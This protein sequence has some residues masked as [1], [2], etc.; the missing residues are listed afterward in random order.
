MFGRSLSG[1]EED[2]EYVQASNSTTYTMITQHD[3]EFKK[4]DLIKIS[5]K[6]SSKV[7]AMGE[8]AYFSRVGSKFEGNMFGHD[9]TVYISKFAGGGQFESK[10]ES[11]PLSPNVLY[12]LEADE[13]IKARKDIDKFVVTTGQ[14]K[15][16]HNSILAGQNIVAKIIFLNNER[17]K[18][19]TRN[20]DF[21][22]SLRGPESDLTDVNP[23]VK[24][25]VGL[26]CITFQVKI[27]KT[28]DYLLFFNQQANST[29]LQGNNAIKL[30]DESGG[31]IPEQGISLIV[32]AGAPSSLVFKSP[33]L[34]VQLSVDVPCFEVAVCDNFRNPVPAVRLKNLAWQ[35]SVLEDDCRFCKDFQV[36]THDGSI[37]ITK[38]RLRETRLRGNEKRLI[39]V[40]LHAD[41]IQCE[42]V[43]VMEV[44]HGPP[45]LLEIENILKNVKCDT[46]L[47]KVTISV[48]DDSK[49]L[50]TT[51]T[52]TLIA[53][54]DNLCYVSDMNDRPPCQLLVENVNQGKIVFGGRNCAAVQGNIFK[55]AF[56]RSTNSYPVD[57]VLELA[58]NERQQAKTHLYQMNGQKFLVHMPL[59]VFVE[60]DFV[61]CDISDR[62]RVH[63]SRIV[64]SKSVL[65]R[66]DSMDSTAASTKSQA[67][68][69]SGARGVQADAVTVAVTVFESAFDIGEEVQ[70]TSLDFEGLWSATIVGMDD[71]GTYTVRWAEDVVDSEQRVLPQ[72]DLKKRAEDLRKKSK[73][74]RRVRVAKQTVIDA[75]QFLSKAFVFHNSIARKGTVSERE[76][77]EA[78]AQI[79]V[80]I[81]AK[82]VYFCDDDDCAKVLY[83]QIDLLFT[84][85]VGM[86]VDTD[87]N[88][89]DSFQTGD[90]V[91]YCRMKPNLIPSGIPKYAELW[92]RDGTSEMLWQ[93]SECHYDRSQVPAAQSYARD[94]VFQL[95]LK[96]RDESGAPCEYSPDMYDVSCSWE[97]NLE[98][99]RERSL[100]VDGSLPPFTLKKSGNLSVEISVINGRRLKLVHFVKMQYGTAAKINLVVN[101]ECHQEINTVKVGQHYSLSF[102][103]LD[104][105]EEKIP[106]SEFFEFNLTQLYLIDSSR[107]KISVQ[108]RIEDHR[109]GTQLWEDVTSTS[110]HTLERDDKDACFKLSKCCFGGKAGNVQLHMEGFVL[111]SGD[112]K[113]IELKSQFLHV[114]LQPGDAKKIMLINNTFSRP[115]LVDLSTIYLTS[116]EIETNTIRVAATDDYGNRLDCQTLSVSLVLLNPETQKSTR[117]DLVKEAN[118][119][120]SATFTAGPYSPGKIE[121]TI[122]GR[123]RGLNLEPCGITIQVEKSNC[124]ESIELGSAQQKMVVPMLQDKSFC[125]KVNAT[126]HTQDKYA[127]PEQCRS[128]CQLLWVGNGEELRRIPLES[129]GD[130]DWEYGRTVNLT[131]PIPWRKPGAYDLRFEYLEKRE[132]LKDVTSN[133]IA[134]IALPGCP[135][136][137][138]SLYMHSFP[139]VCWPCDSSD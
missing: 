18:V 40:R 93:V 89:H 25:E 112:K 41:A 118:D 26:G 55:D 95:F 11:F 126:F 88:W 10:L 21:N 59:G 39:N 53:I 5:K 22:V 33:T 2:G 71:D 51:A 125:I 80:D 30:V 34:Q 38:L 102:C 109:K 131:V 73:E 23:T 31:D 79:P 29:N 91:L 107:T 85:S 96:F 87:I 82:N 13:V 97:S 42:G 60:G 120:Y 14:V 119:L 136:G 110:D 12:Q 128:S 99:Q 64:N 43:F 6:N 8:I 1:E 134:V 36:D 48:I 37:T 28:G 15:C 123:S 113:R 81:F 103:L 72:T 65:A 27:D 68:G 115:D 58:L 7:E 100:I 78:C 54:S 20:C 46:A 84:E 62:E 101:D 4:G 57:R 127:L 90:K 117:W 66:I 94:S 63:A 50:C 74:D 122:S 69:S 139:L 70:A 49:N 44:S 61:M 16:S 108:A 138:H 19:E 133:S 35:F 98:G 106:V 104:V 130:V 75:K 132:G 52:G 111:T 17:Q 121:G 105:F 114:E 76:K 92:Q 116:H 67:R 32:S 129:C 45:S 24:K 135:S 137:T 9:G 124:V 86:E 56:P 83:A 3:K 47:P 77:A